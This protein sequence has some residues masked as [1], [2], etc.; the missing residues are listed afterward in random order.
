MNDEKYISAGV[1][2]YMKTSRLFRD[3]I[4]SHFKNIFQQKI[5]D[6]FRKFFVS[7]LTTFICQELQHYATFSQTKV[8]DIID[9]LLDYLKRGIVTTIHRFNECDDC[10]DEVIH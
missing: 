8:T 9:E 5:D 2:V 1:S 4:D 7:C 6:Q 3:E 10:R